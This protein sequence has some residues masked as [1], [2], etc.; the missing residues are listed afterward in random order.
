MYRIFWILLVGLFACENND[1]VLTDWTRNI[2]LREEAVNM[3]S[4]LS[5]GGV[6]RAK[7]KAPRMYR[8]SADTVYAEFPQTLHCDF[9]NAATLLETKLDSKYGIYYENLNRVFLRDSVVVVTVKGD[10]LMSQQLWWDQNT[11]RF[12]TDAPVTFKSSGR[13]IYGAKGLE[14]T[15]DLSR[16]TFRE[17]VGQ[18]R[19]SESGMPY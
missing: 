16:I 5:Q 10:T 7:L 14:A 11:Q 18:L 1:Q 17:T 13:R 19:V 9:F 15:Q 8:V 3:E 4:F 6:L 2:Q 12:Y